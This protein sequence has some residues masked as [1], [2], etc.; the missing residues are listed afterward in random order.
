ML[1]GVH[2]GPLYLPMY[3]KGSRDSGT[4]M[5]KSDD[6]LCTD[7]SNVSDMMNKFYVN[8]AAQI[9]GQVDLP[10]EDLSNCE[11][12]DKC[13]DLYKNH[14]SITQIYN[15]RSDVNFA[16]NSIEP[17]EV[18]KIISGLETKKATGY[19]CIPP[20]L[21]KPVAT[22]LSP[23]LSVIFN[24]CVDKSI[25]PENAKMAEVIPLFKKDDNLIMKNYRPVSI[26]PSLSKVLEKIIHLQLQPFV[27]EVL[28]SRMSAYRKGYSCQHVLIDLIERWKK[29]L[30]NKGHAGA[31]LMDLSKAFD[32]LPP[33]LLIAKLK[34]YGLSRDSCALIWSYLSTR[35]QRVK[36]SGV[37]SGWQF[38]IKGVP[39][40]SILGPVLFNVFLNDLYLFVKNV[41]LHNYADD[42]T[43]SVVKPNIQEVV[44]SLTREAEVAVDW[45]H[46]NMMEANP[47]KFQAIVLKN[48]EQVLFNIKG[49]GIKS[50]ENVKL[51]GVDIDTNLDF[52][53]YVNKLC[54][55]TGAQL[56]V[57]QRLSRYL[58]TESKLIIVRCFILSHFKYCELVWHFC[59]SRNTKRL[60]RIQYRAL[61]FVYS[62][63]DSSYEHL[64]AKANLPTLELSR[65]RSILIEVYKAVNSLSPP[66]ICDLF[67]TYKV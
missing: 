21:L 14:D 43:L 22:S 31:I 13:V 5:I 4:I 66:F 32:C 38:L 41:D 56:K 18:Q 28:D 37:T 55:K 20:K 25:F 23:V 35:K 49:N 46:F 51:L 39:Q 62:D 3:N 7:P 12:V 50:E 16:F 15:Q 40:G 17:D 30:D 29:G 53:Y 27:D 26:L 8:I 57:L 61:K 60:E 34:A 19:D 59:G 64:L 36:L 44:A 2:G 9:G 42:N 24:Q 65:K 11:Y 33:Q 47:N 58:D 63:F 45:F 52:C 67:E 1:R 10:Q 48:K 54:R 6:G